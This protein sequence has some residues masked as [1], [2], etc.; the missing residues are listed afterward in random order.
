MEKT[1][2]GLIC[3]YGLLPEVFIQKTY[4]NYNLFVVSFKNFFPKNIRKYTDNFFILKNWEL[5][6]I[7]D[8]F[9]NNSVK[10]IVFLGY[11]PHLLL[12]KKNNFLNMDL[13]TKNMFNKLP[14]YKAL[15]IFHALV[16]EF[17]K[18]NITIEPL[19]K[20]LESEFA[21]SGS[22]NNLELTEFDLENIKFGYDIAKQ[23]SA[24]DVGLTTVVKNKIVIAL[25]A[26]EGTDN[27]ILRGYKIAGK[28]C[29]VIKVARPQQ[30]MRFD[31]PVIGPRTIKIANRAKV[32][33]IAV[34]SKKTLILNKQEVIE[35]SKKLKI[36]L[37]GI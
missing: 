30:D 33:A 3:G 26:A 23:L 27:C 13:R 16:E 28:N 4:K 15:N 20:F 31:L 5:Q 34:E 7:I 22:I 17:Q 12:L 14:T 10:N 1:N 19:N 2:I 24:L 29:Y 18:E 21:P 32:S 11:I 37:Y 36:K 6:K 8:Y 25:E 35:K 9:K